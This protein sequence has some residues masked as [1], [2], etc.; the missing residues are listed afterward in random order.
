[1]VFKWFFVSGVVDLIFQ[2]FQVRLASIFYVVLSICN[3]YMYR[4]KESDSLLFITGYYLVKNT[5]I[6]KF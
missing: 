3:K 1:M 5:H 6:L 4:N 2:A